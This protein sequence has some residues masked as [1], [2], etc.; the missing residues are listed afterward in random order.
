MLRAIGPAAAVDAVHRFDVL[1]L[2]LLLVVHKGCQSIDWQAQMY[3][4]S[5]EWL[6]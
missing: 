3:F 1:L 6:L 4:W 5:I 2:L